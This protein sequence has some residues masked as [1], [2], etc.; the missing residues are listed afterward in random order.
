MCAAAGLRDWAT[1]RS[2][3]RFGP[4]F[5]Q[6]CIRVCVGSIDPTELVHAGLGRRLRQSFPPPV[7]VEL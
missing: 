4:R 2:S 5:G 6:R 1:H 7:Y 3:S